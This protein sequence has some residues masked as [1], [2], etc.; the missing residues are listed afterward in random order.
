MFSVLD[1]LQR[2]N[3]WDL[4]TM[5]RASHAE[6]VLAGLEDSLNGPEAEILL[7][8]ARRAV[9]SVRTMQSG[10]FLRRQLG[11]PDVELLLDDGA[12]RHLSLE[13]AAASY[14]KLLRDATHGHGGQGRAAGQ[15]A[16]LLAH[17]D[18]DV[19]HDIGL[20]AYLYLLD[21]LVQPHRVRRCLYSGGR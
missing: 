14:L 9:E 20:L 1:S 16:A 21:I 4:I 10:F 17:H 11:T 12:V 8:M 6:S 7:P 5:F 3:G 15:T 18:G 13:E 2:L 19:P